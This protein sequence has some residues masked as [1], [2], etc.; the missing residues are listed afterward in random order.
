MTI[1]V[2]V[3]DAHRMFREGLKSLL[4]ACGDIEVVESAADGEAALL[5]IGSGAIDVVVVDTQLPPSS[6]IRTIERIRSCPSAPPCVAL[7]SRGSRMEPGRAMSSGASAFLHKTCTAD[8]LIEAIRVVSSGQCYVPPV[9]AEDLIGALGRSE[10]GNATGVV[11]LTAREREVLELIA[12][13]HSSRQIARQL[14]VST[15]TVNSHRARLMGKLGVC[16][17]ASLV[18]FAVREGLIA[19]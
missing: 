5:A 8:E 6:G 14:G 12:D 11:N 4:E 15:R 18:R 17:T 7:S 1:R 16:K 19:A 2:L 9:V 3:C 10:H 13:S